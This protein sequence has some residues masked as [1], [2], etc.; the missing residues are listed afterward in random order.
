M[1]KK[2]VKL[3]HE[4]QKTNPD[5]LR[6]CAIIAAA[7][8]SSRMGEG[9]NKPLIELCGHT[10]LEW[11]VRAYADSA[12]VKSIVITCREADIEVYKQ[13]PLI[14]ECVKPC[15]F[16]VGG[17]TRQKSVGSAFEVMMRDFKDAQIVAIHDAARP[18]IT[19]ADIDAV[20]ADCLK[21]GAAAA[22]TKVVDTLKRA[23]EDGF[24]DRTVNRSDLWAVQ[25]PQVFL[26]DLYLVAMALAER[27][28]YCV[29]DDCS[30]A[31]HAGFDVRLTPTSADNIK[32]TYP[33]DTALAEMIMRT[34]RK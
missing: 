10:A 2:A 17:D 5:D 21:Y 18:L 24:I 27:D 4:I 6:V 33:T 9:A 16:S 1:L 14:R 26:R 13:L 32:L 30:L 20:I 31:E 25:T 7:G 28:G 23:R 34:R 3:I 15:S 29:T 11:S 19:T 22:S 12:F 8:S